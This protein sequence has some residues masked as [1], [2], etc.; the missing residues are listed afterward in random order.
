[1]INTDRLTH[2]LFTL[3][4]I[5][6]QSTGGITRLAFTK[7]DSDA[8]LL[9]SSFMK[10]AGLIV[11]EDEAGNLYGR[12]EGTDPDAPVVLT[13]SHIDSVYDGGI[14]DGNLGVIGAIEALQVMN[15]QGIQTKHPIEVCA[16]KDEEGIRFCF[17]MTGSR[18]IAGILKPEDLEHQDKQ[19]VSISQAMTMCGLDPAQIGKAARAAGSI[20]AHVEL[21][22]EQGRVLESNNLPLG[23]VTGINSSLWLHVTIEGE[24]GHAGA[25]PMEIRHDSLSAAAEIILIVE[26]ESRKTG[27]S[28]GTVGKIHA[29]P[30]G[31]NIIP[32]KVEFSIDLRDINQ[33]TGDSLEQAILKRANEVCKK[34]G[35]KMTVE[36]LQRVPPVPCSS[37]VQNVIKDAFGKTGLP[38]FS[39]P[40]GAGHD[41][42]HIARICPIGMIFVRSQKGISHNPEEWSTEE[43]CAAGV[44]VLYHT[45]I[46]LAVESKS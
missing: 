39:L 42:M 13:G 21:H 27:T 9:V 19:G 37:V 16:F 23:I 5:G 14:F 25:T 46:N 38:V 12:R 36:V 30:G 43:D 24:A 33:E 4:K 17:S 26:E 44:E 6:A 2:R 28:V 7:E 1:M 41:S 45:L 11:R 31:I 40:S 10:E 22:I 34:R 20:K 29:F 3:G 18:A 8:R 32:G 15:E 35:V